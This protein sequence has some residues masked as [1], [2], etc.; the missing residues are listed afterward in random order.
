VTILSHTLRNWC[1][2]SIHVIHQ[3]MRINVSYN[4]F[5]LNNPQKRQNIGKILKK[6]YNWCTDPIRVIH[7]SMR[8][9]VSYYKYVLNNPQKRQNIGKIFKKPYK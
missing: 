4:K 5:V 9:N 3:S 6:P 8:I 2:D 1:T 7:Q